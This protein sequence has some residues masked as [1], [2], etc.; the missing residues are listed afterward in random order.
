M[1]E[2]IRQLT[3]QALG[4][5]VPDAKAGVVSCYGTVNYDRGLCSSAAVLTRGRSA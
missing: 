4:A 5:A 2:A 3:G 1:T